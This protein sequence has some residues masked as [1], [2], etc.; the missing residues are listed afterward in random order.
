MVKIVGYKSIQKENGDEFLVLVL[1]GGIELVKSQVTGKNYFTARTVNVPATFDEETC[2]SLVGA[3][4]EGTIKKVP[5][6]P[7]DYVIRETGE[8]VTLGYRYEFVDSNQEVL[9]EH[10]VDKELVI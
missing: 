4:F 9:A 1:Q 3:E 6:E 10:L 7:Y 5:C 2:K 8:V